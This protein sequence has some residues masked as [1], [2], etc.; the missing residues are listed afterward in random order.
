[1]F[2]LNIHTWRNYLKLKYKPSGMNEPRTFF[3]DT[4]SVKY[5]EKIMRYAV[6]Q[7]VEALH[8]KS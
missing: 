3:A 6:A 4:N 8:Y 5:S 2:L 7:F 1:M